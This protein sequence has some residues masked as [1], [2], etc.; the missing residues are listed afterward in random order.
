MRSGLSGFGGNEFKT[1]VLYPNILCEKVN[2]KPPSCTCAG[3]G[4]SMT[5]S[6]VLNTSTGYSGSARV[7]AATPVLKIIRSYAK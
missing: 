7:L 2:L 3:D 4:G 6:F 5:I 1:V